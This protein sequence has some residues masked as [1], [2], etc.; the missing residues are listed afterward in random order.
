M[1]QMF[2]RC[3]ILIL[4]LFF[5]LTSSGKC[6]EL[7]DY[8]LIRRAFLEI[9]NVPPTPSELEWYIVYNEDSYKTAVEWIVNQ[10][11]IKKTI[12]IDDFSLKDYLNSD[13][14]KTKEFSI[15]DDK[16]LN[17]IVCYQTGNS[18]NN[19][20]SAN[21]DMI[22]LA[23]KFGEGDVLGTIDYMS[24]C[25]ISRVTNVN[26]ANKYLKI[27]KQYPSEQEGYQAVL[28]AIKITEDFILY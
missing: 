14:F 2:C 8:Q 23:I 19:I 28:N 13:Y 15:L 10:T 16:V 21:L 1:K 11:K 18:L 12:Y 9:L 25:L 22:E 4:I 5:G 6:I 26:E 27:F 17:F 20:N 7:K 24:L 3:F